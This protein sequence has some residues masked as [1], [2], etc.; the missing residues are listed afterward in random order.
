VLHLAS[1]TP[2]RE[3][4]GT[5]TAIALT[6]WLTIVVIMWLLPTII[7]ERRGVANV[8]SIAVLNVFLGWLPAVWV[9]C[10]ALPARASL[11]RLHVAAGAAALSGRRGL[12]RRRTRH[13]LDS[14]AGDRRGAAHCI[15]GRLAAVGLAGQPRVATHGSELRRQHPGW[16]R[17][18]GPDANAAAVRPDVGVNTDRR[19]VIDCVGAIG[20][21]RVSVPASTRSVPRD[22]TLQCRRSVELAAPTGKP[23]RRRHARHRFDV[24]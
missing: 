24:G 9:I 12:P 1:T 2:S 16:S 18:V 17:S 23:G 20:R 22:R 10:L 19:I 4:S 14:A 13:R 8:G 15:S 7:A 6:I 11:T 21:R 3:Y 5:E